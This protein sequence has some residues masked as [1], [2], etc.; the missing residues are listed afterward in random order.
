MLDRLLG[1]FS[2]DLA[3]DLGTANT[4]VYAKGRGIVSSEPSVVAV[5]TDSRGVDR[6]RAVGKDA[7]S[8]LGRT[9]GNIQA[10]R[11]TAM[12]ACWRLAA[13]LPATSEVALA[14]YRVSEAGARVVAAAQH[15]H[16][17]MGVDRDYPVHRFYLYAKQLELE[18]GGTTEQL[19]RIGRVLADMPLEASA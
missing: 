3:I 18:L 13:G 16:G 2:N 17:G 7:K 14:K 9:P 5:L 10:I 4:L 19:R 11:L 8:M 1:F 12:Q 15:L 6:V